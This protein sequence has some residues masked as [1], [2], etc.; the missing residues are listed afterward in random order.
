MNTWL[1]LAL[2]AGGFLVGRLYQWIRDAQH[3]MGAG[4]SGRR[5]R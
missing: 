5:P 1:L 2:I 3:V 4:R